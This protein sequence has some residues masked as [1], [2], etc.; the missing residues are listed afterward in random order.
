MEEEI[1]F[2]TPQEM[3]ATTIMGGNID[4]DKYTFCI[5]DV[6]EKVIQELLGTDLYDKIV[7]DLENDIPLVGDYLILFNKFVKPITKFEAC[8]DY[9]TISNYNLTN[10][11]LLKN[12]G[13]DKEIV[14]LEE[15]QILS[16]RYHAKAQMYIR[17]FD[18]WICNNPIEEYRT[19]QDEVNAQKNIMLN[20]SWNLGNNEVR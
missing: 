3:T 12:G 15:V 1:L 19:S 20:P 4:T 10:K 14:P 9:I 5:S 11:G 17:R 16:E 2:I 18:K 6:Q 13:T 8:A 7:E